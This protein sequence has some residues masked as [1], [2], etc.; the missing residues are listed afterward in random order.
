[1]RYIYTVVT[2]IPKYKTEMI[3][4]RG[5]V[6]HSNILMANFGPGFDFLEG[7]QDLYHN[8][9]INLNK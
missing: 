7:K 2:V 4:D 3:W 9:Y 1:M 8:Y 5:C 6:H